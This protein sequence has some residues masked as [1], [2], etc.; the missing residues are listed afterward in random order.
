MQD[1]DATSKSRSKS[2]TLEGKL[3]HLIETTTAHICHKD[4]QRIRMMKQCFGFAT[5]SRCSA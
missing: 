3:G 1:C 4:G 5:V 2:D